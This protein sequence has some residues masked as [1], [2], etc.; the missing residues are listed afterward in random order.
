MTDDK[1]TLTRRRVLG[2]MATIGAAGAVGAG[3]W[4]Q[5]SDE[6]TGR[7]VA[8]A[9]TLDLRINGGDRRATVDVGQLSPEDNVDDPDS[10]PHTFEA[11][12]ELTNVGNTTGNRVEVVIPSAG[13]QS[14]ERDNPEPETNTGGQGELDDQLEVRA[15]LDNDS[16]DGNGNKGY[17]FGGSDSYVPFEDVLDNTYGVNE[18][19]D[20]GGGDSD[21]LVIQGRF[22]DREDNNE[23]MGDR[24]RFDVEATLLQN[25]A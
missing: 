12:Y 2:S 18:N 5:F 8:Q 25:E 23:A 20:G 21:D 3:A 14:M 9:G 1:P 19:I 22:P 17:F 24:V 4:A 6:E 7:V 16:N 11:R 13:V 10:P 15:F